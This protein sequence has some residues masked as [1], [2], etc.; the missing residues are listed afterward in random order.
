MNEIRNVTLPEELCRRA[1]DRFGHRFSSL[2]EL[3][4]SALNE[5]LRD[6]S[7]AMDEKETKIIEERLKGLGYI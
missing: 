6:D 4:T 1:E 3:L 7:I 5:L 2:E